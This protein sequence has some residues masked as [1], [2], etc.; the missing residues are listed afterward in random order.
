MNQLSHECGY[1]TASS[2][3]GIYTVQNSFGLLIYTAS[4]DSEGT[5]GGL[6]RMSDPVSLANVIAKT[7]RSMSWCS[8]DPICLESVG[9]GL[10]GLNEA[11]CHACCLVPETSCEYANVLLNR[12]FSVGHYGLFSKAFAELEGGH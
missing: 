3:E 4:G 7:L 1:P 10:S 2:R 9:Q 12:K 8:A 6:V 11:A 5:L